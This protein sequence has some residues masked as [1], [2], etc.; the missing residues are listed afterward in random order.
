MRPFSL[1]RVRSKRSAPG[2]TW[3]REDVRQLRELA[4]AGVPAEVIAV[5]LRRTY[6]AVRNKAGMH[7]I[8]LKRRERATQESALAVHEDVSA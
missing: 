3:S 8:S 2:S 6:S 7:G 4:V 5:Q 1:Q